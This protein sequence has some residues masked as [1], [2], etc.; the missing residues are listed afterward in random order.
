MI[1]T[2]QFANTDMEILFNSRGEFLEIH[3]WFCLSR[4]TVNDLS[5]PLLERA[6]HLQPLWRLCSLCQEVH[7]ACSRCARSARRLRTDCEGF[8]RSAKRLHTAWVG[9][10]RA[11][12]RRHIDCVRSARSSKGSTIECRG[13]ARSASKQHS[14]WGGFAHPRRRSTVNGGDWFDPSQRTAVR[15]GTPSER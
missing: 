3:P 9:L 8:A 13:V 14:Q 4:W 2:C 5:P 11:R 15:G 7:T 12:Q 1:S 10:I 6:A